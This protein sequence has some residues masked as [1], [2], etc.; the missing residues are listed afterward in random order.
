MEWYNEPP[1]WDLDGKNLSVYSAP[2]TDFWR[3]THSGAVEDNGHFYYE[4]VSGDFIAEVQVTGEYSALYD[5]AGLMLRV[6]NENWLKCGIEF[7]EG[8]KNMSAV[9]TRDFSD[10]SL[11]PLVSNPPR[12]WLRVS[13]D[14]NTATVNYSLDGVSF[15]MFRQA[16]LP[17]GDRDQVGVMCASPTGN[18][19]QVTF[20]D[21][22]ITQ[23]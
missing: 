9:V 23:L 8:A 16:F 20:D 7:F 21:F 18:G 14:G 10:W 13:R 12:L 19:F 3:K 4:E 15:S 6:S 17:M 1:S 11:V 22:E 5:Q 2:K